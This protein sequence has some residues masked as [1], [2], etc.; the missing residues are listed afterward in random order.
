MKV[1]AGRIEEYVGYLA[2]VEILTSLLDQERKALAEALIET[3]FTKDQNILTQ[4]QPGS[5][6]YILVE[7]EVTIIQDNKETTTLSAS[8]GGGKSFGERAL[9]TDEQRNATVKVRSETAKALALDRDSFNLI[10]GPLQEIINTEGSKRTSH[11]RS[12]KN[13][14]ARDADREKILRKDLIK[15]GL[16]GCG[17]FGAVE[18]YEHTTT[19]ATYALK[20]LS[21]GYVVKTGMQQSVMNEK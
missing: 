8:R 2:K 3:H 7:G 13:K 18:L 19:K 20:S 14:S 6:F 10:L 15:L 4:G 1:S 11:V 21:K 12:L 9:L 17:G 16:L 5:T